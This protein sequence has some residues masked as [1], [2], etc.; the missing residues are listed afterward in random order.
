M[1]FPVSD[2]LHLLYEWILEGF[3]HVVGPN[4]LQT[5]CQH[6]MQSLLRAVWAASIDSD[7]LVRHSYRKV[8]PTVN[9]SSVRRIIKNWLSTFYAYLF[10]LPPQTNRVQHAP[11]LAALQ[12]LLDIFVANSLC[13]LYDIPHIHRFPTYIHIRSWVA[14]ETHVCFSAKENVV[15]KYLL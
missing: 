10:S 5:G 14:R 6:G 13:F 3:S 7:T 11:P 15:K 1:C 4:K 2:I 8:V 12:F 9:G